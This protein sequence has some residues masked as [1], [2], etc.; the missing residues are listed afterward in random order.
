MMNRTILQEL[1][2]IR[3]DEA[4][5]LLE[6]EKYNGA[7]D[8]S[9]YIIELALKACIAKGTEKYDFPQYRIVD[10]IYTDKLHTIAECCFIG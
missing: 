8:L 7:Y 9:G 1:A 6:N 4:K 2:N 5:T 3:H 10:K